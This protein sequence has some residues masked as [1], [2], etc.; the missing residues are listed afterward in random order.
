MGIG[1]NDFGHFPSGDHYWIFALRIY[2]EE[3]DQRAG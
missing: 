3:A 1:L 2:G